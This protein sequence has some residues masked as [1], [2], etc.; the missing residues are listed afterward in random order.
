[1][2]LQPLYK[3]LHDK[4]SGA[5]W[6]EAYDTVIYL[7]EQCDRIEQIT[8]GSDISPETAEHIK[9]VWDGCDRSRKHE[10]MIMEAV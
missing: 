4:K 9:F 8:A 2:L 10:I 3:A 6:K 7:I 5:A 1:M